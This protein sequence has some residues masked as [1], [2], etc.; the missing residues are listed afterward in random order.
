MRIN[1]RDRETCNREIGVSL[2]SESVL[3]LERWQRLVLSQLSLIALALYKRF[4]SLSR[5]S[6][7]SRRNGSSATLERFQQWHMLAV[8]LHPALPD[9]TFQITLE[10]LVERF[11]SSLPTAMSYA[12]FRA[13]FT[14]SA[15][16]KTESRDNKYG[17]PDAGCTR[18]YYTRV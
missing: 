1:Y 11:I 2:S 9:R 6:V 16:F 10:V 12:L 18:I 4:Q 8:Y 5:F 14:I 15:V 13:A 7:N 3:F 17:F